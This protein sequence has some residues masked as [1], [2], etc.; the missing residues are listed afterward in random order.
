[1]TKR[2]PEK[3]AA[4]RVPQGRMPLPDKEPRANEPPLSLYPLDFETALK[5]AIDAGR[6]PGRKGKPNDSNR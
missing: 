1:M 2:T 5:G 6:Y 4:A 3:R